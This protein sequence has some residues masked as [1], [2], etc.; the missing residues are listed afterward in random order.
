[1]TT[2][3]FIRFFLIVPLALCML[4]ACGQKGPLVLPE[5]PATAEAEPAP[6]APSPAEARPSAV[7]PSVEESTQPAH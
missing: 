1:M 4:G 2:E 7:S 3:R 5:R 6:A